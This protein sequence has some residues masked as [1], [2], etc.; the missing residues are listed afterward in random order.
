MKSQSVLWSQAILLLGPLLFHKPGP[1]Q[2]QRLDWVHFWLSKNWTGSTFGW[3]K[4]G[5]GPLLAEQKLDWVHFWQSFGVGVECIPIYGGWDLGWI[6]FRQLYW[7]VYGTMIWLGWQYAWNT[8]LEEWALLFV[9]EMPTCGTT[10]SLPFHLNRLNFNFVFIIGL[11]VLFC[12]V[13]FAC[14]MHVVMSFVIL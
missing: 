13:L 11:L 5:L 10:G 7:V 6:H 9:K 4:T 12:L 14:F 1:E 3:A 2:L 8:S